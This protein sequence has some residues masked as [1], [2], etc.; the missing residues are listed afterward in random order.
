MHPQC[1]VKTLNFK[2]HNPTWQSATHSN[3]NIPI[4]ASLTSPTFSKLPSRR[5]NTHTSIFSASSVFPCPIS[6]RCR[7]TGPG[8]VTNDDSAPTTTVPAT[9]VAVHQHL[10]GVPGALNAPNTVLA[11]IREDLPPHIEAILV[12]KPDH[13]LRRDT[14]DAATQLLLEDATLLLLEV[15]TQ[16]FPLPINGSTIPSMD[17]VTRETA[18]SVS[19]NANTSPPT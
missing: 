7:T 10:L 6:Q 4:A 18:H 8:I 5:H 13:P 14:L 12:I 19:A 9:P 16:L 1:H 17:S 2:L 15:A 3:S 11:Q